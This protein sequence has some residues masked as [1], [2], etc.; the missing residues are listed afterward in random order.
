MLIS[1]LQMQWSKEMN[2]YVYILKFVDG[3]KY[4][5]V[6]S[7][8]LTPKL[9]TCYLGSG[10]ALPDRNRDTC[11]KI[12]LKTFSTRKEA[13]EYEKYLIDTLDCVNSSNYYNLRNYNHDKHGSTCPA[14]SSALAGRTKEDYVYI[15]KANEKRSKYIGNNRTPAQLEADKR[16]RET[17]KGIPNA[18]KGHKS[19]DNCAFKPWYYINAVGQL[20]QV[21]DQTKQEYAHKLGLTPRQLVHRFHYS[22]INKPAKQGKCKGWIFGNVSDLTGE[23]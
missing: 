22:N 2:H 17:T 14:T 19:T 21:F 13:T 3:M 11:V 4:I 12:I 10:S 15:R 18:A 9:D 6:R 23:V 20:T 8:H 1:V 5:G 7:T 16:L